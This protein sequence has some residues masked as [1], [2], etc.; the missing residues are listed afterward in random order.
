MQTRS[1]IV[2][3]TA[4]DILAA[5]LLKEATAAEEMRQTLIECEIVLSWGEIST[6]EEIGKALAM[7]R[8]ALSKAVPN[9]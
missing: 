6:K 2:P 5:D 4:A 7:V 9:K 8:S 1:K 3:A